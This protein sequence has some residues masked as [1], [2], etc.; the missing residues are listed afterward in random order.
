MKVGIMQPY[1]MPYIGYFQLIKTVD[2]YVIYNDVNFIQR[3]WVARNNI[4]IG[5][6]RQM[7]SI[8]L[9]GASQNKHFTDIYVLDDFSKLSKT[10]KINYAKAPYF[11]PVMELMNQ[12]FSFQERRLDLFLTNSIKQ[13]LSY[14]NIQ[15]ELVLSS[16]I[17]KDN[18]L[19]GQDKILAICKAL[20]TDTYYNAIG[21][22][23]L[24][25]KAEFERNGITLFFLQTQENLS[26]QQFTGIQFVPNLSIIDVLMFNSPEKVN[27]LLNQYQ[28]I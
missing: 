5:G 7:F 8:S 18:S 6:K 4:L 20:N 17:Q 16:D 24:Y 9:Q 28:L 10:L 19:K 21:G 12:V 2:K 23:G 22:Q 15:T 13:V 26:Y 3:G 11:H 27:D 25:D 1:F 14:L